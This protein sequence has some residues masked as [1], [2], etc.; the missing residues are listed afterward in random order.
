MRMLLDTHILVWA[1]KESPLLP[2]QSAML[3]EDSSNELYFSTAAV[4]EACIKH[5]KRPDQFPLPGERL[6]RYCT[7]NGIK[8]LPLYF[9]H[10]DMLNTLVQQENAPAHNDPFDKIMIAQAKTDNLFFLTHDSLLRY[11]DEPCILYV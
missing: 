6:I 7:D 9:R 8:E 2:A 4:W 1:I 10:I 5:A 3:I 11:Y